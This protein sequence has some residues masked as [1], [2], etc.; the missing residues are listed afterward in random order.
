MRQP[1]GRALSRSLDG[2]HV[3]GTA[4]QVRREEFLSLGQGQMQVA[5]AVYLDIEEVGGEI[6]DVAAVSAI[7]TDAMQVKTGDSDGLGVGG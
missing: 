6:E 3:A 2:I 7:V 4:G 1:G 5:H